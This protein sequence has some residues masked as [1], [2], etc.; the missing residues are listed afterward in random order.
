[1]PKWR[2]RISNIDTQAQVADCLEC[3]PKI[4][5]KFK[6]HKKLW[7]C[8]FALHKTI[9]TTKRWKHLM[10]NACEICGRTENLIA[11]HD[12]KTKKFRGTLCTKCNVGIGL[13]GDTLE[14][15]LKAENYLRR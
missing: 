6:P 8:Y 2:H 3:G 11:D 12:H 5:V 15:I 1:M 7:V 4:R 14:G 13:L 10:K 9:G